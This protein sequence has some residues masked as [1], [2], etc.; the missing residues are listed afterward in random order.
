MRGNTVKHTRKC[1]AAS[2]IAAVE[3]HRDAHWTSYEDF[4]I[5][6]DHIREIA[7]G[8]LDEG[9]MTC[10]CAS[11][12]ETDRNGDSITHFDPGESWV[13]IARRDYVRHGTDI[14]T[15]ETQ[16]EHWASKI[17][18]ATSLVTDGWHNTLIDV[19]QWVKIPDRVPLRS[20]RTRSVSVLDFLTFAHDA[21]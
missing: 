7:Q 6:L 4:L 8:Y 16:R 19:P 10:T 20:D 14:V 11:P 1:L 2:A 15:A 13:Q 12:I 3:N 18:Y 17:E 5:G 9:L 21:L